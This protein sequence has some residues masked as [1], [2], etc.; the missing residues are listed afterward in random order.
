[1]VSRVCADS[2]AVSRSPSGN[3]IGKLVM[4]AGI[5]TALLASSAMGQRPLGLDVSY[6]QGNLTQANWNTVHASG[7]D[8]V[9]VR[10][11]HYSAPG[12]TD[13]HGSPDPYFVNNI[14][15]ARAAGMLAGAYSFVR[16]TIRDPITEADFFLT[17]ARPYITNG[18]LRPMLDLEDGTATV[19]AANLSDWANAWLDRVQ[20]QTGVE[21]VI[22]CNSNYARNYL[23]STLA[24]RTLWLA[25][26][27]QLNGDPQTMVPPAG[28]TGI[29]PT[30]AFWQY[31]NQGNGTGVAVPGI[32]ARVDLDVFNGTMAELQNYVIGGGTPVITNVQATNVA[33]NN[34]TITWTTNTA[35]TSQVEYGPTTSYGYMSPLDGITVTSHSVALS[36]LAANTLYHYRV[37]STNN[38]GPSY[39]SDDTFTTTGPLIISNVM[40]NPVTFNSAT[41][42]WTTNQ[43]ASSEV[44]YG[45]TGG[46]GSSTTPDMNLVTSHSVTLTNLSPTTLYHYQVVSSIATG[47][48]ES[49]D[50]T[51]TTTAAPT[52]P[53]IS[54]V[55][56]GGLTSD[57]VTI[58]W[59]TDVASDS[60]VE[61][62]T[63]ADYG[64]SSALNSSPVTSHAVV[65]PN[66]SPSTV[67]HYRVRSANVAGP[68]YSSDGTFTTL[69]LAPPVIFNVTASGVNAGSA[70]IAWTT[71]VVSD[72]QVEYGTTTAYGAS[73]TLNPSLVTSHSVVLGT[74]IPSTL[75]HYRVRSANAAGS[76]WSGDHTFTTTAIIA[77]IVIDNTEAITTGSW[78]TGTNAL[79][80]KIGT[81]YLYS[82]P[83]S[84]GATSTCTWRPSLEVAG[85]YDVYVY[86]QI[87]ANRNSAATFTV[88]YD[89]GQIASTQNQYSDTPNQGGWFLVGQDLPFA[90]GTGGYVQVT[91]LSSAGGYISADAAKFVF[92]SVLAVDVTAAVSRKTHGSVGDFDVDILMA[93]AVECRQAGPTSI[94]VTFS[95]SIAQ[96]TGTAADVSVSS[97][98]VSGLTID[99]NRLL[100]TMSGAADASPLAIAFPGIRGTAGQNITHTLCVGVLLG[101][102]TGDKQAN[103]VDLLNMKANVNQPATAANFRNDITTDGVINVFDLLANR[104]NLNKT[105][106]GCP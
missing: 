66:L 84:S 86:Y 21:P 39:S 106:N 46:Y 8:F 34:A 60:Q 77:E 90:A 63:T 32:S 94:L 97:G 18:Y 29:F 53:V 64:S 52:S 19:G 83:S 57:S 6:W 47:A 22:Y 62:G 20:Q 102:V 45:L 56:V 42:T 79:V 100:I 43:P 24:S 13:A 75:Y 92:K 4:L 51:F 105:V 70:T 7:W 93:G 81:S 37:I 73:S 2:W 28:A 12:E 68:S 98:T 61:Y 30:W 76:A 59:T 15:R 10:A 27:G 78:N 17:Y 55:S 91:N 82:N 99:G 31:S 58:T 74:L 11:T 41:I 48:V 33:N 103:V 71:D 67:Y 16:N 25:N 96:V 3:S 44:R 36:G 9:I 89:G 35:A 85:L 5:A 14:T 88:V 95:R 54:N 87:G 26:W 38:N 101:D 40:A 23:N 72:S 80:P 65:I 69:D 50:Y 104:N 49:A 1:M